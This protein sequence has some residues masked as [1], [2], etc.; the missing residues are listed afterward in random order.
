[1][2]D[3]LHQREPGPAPLV[4]SRDLYAGYRAH[5]HPRP[6][7]THTTFARVLALEGLTRIRRA[8]GVHYYE[9]ELQHV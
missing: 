6:T 4:A 5:T 9:A 3:Y 8:A 7:C 1:M 2:L